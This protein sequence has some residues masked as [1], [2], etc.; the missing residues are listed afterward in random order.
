MPEAD[1]PDS[2]ALSPYFAYAYW[3]SGAGMVTRTDGIQSGASNAEISWIYSAVPPAGWHHE[4]GSVAGS[5]LSDV[6]PPQPSILA[7]GDFRGDPPDL[8]IDPF[9]LE[10]AGSAYWSGSL[11]FVGQILRYDVQFKPLPT[12]DG[13]HLNPGVLGAFIEIDYDGAF[14]PYSISI[15]GIWPVSLTPDPYYVGT[16]GQQYWAPF[17]LYSSPEALPNENNPDGSIGSRIV[18][19]SNNNYTP[20]AGDTTGAANNYRNTHGFQSS[21]QDV[22]SNRT[23]NFQLHF[24]PPM[25]PPIFAGQKPTLPILNIRKVRTWR[26]FAYASPIPNVPQEIEIHLDTYEARTGL[27]SHPGT[28]TDASGWSIYAAMCDYISRPVDIVLNR[29]TTQSVDVEPPDLHR[30]VALIIAAPPADLADP[31]STIVCDIAM[32]SATLRGFLNIPVGGVLG[33]TLAEDYDLGRDQNLGVEMVLLPNGVYANVL[34]FPNDLFPAVA[35]NYYLDQSHANDADIGDYTVEG[36][37]ALGHFT[38]KNNIG[39]VLVDTYFLMAAQVRIANG[40][41]DED[42]FFNFPGTHVVAETTF[43]LG[44]PLA[45]QLTARVNGSTY[46]FS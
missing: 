31:P 13:I 43:Y 42:T 29:M 45:L 2:T 26:H 34:V 12:N 14:A 30:D 19:R 17:Y 6:F 9:D 38:G 40:P 24:T 23:V 18:L 5:F 35:R 8:F 21:G 39:Q 16:D 32:N 7:T 1:G 41:D 25:G 33:D 20:P 10:E 44:T 27:S 22:L 4:S 3:N 15:D 28:A 11:P 46:K 36:S 37:N